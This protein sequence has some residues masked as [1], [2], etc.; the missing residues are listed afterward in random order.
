LRVSDRI[1][2]T[3]F[4]DGVETILPSTWTVDK[5]RIFEV[6]A[7]ITAGGGTP[8]YAGWLEGAT[9]VCQ[10]CRHFQS[11]A[12]NRVILISDGQVNV[13]E[14]NSDT[15]AIDVSELARRGVS[16]SV[17]G[18]GDEVNENL[19]S[20]IAMNLSNL[21]LPIPLLLSSLP[22]FLPAACIGSATP[23]QDQ[24]PSRS[25]RKVAFDINSAEGSIQIIGNRLI[26]SKQL[27]KGL[28]NEITK[29]ENKLDE[30]TRGSHSNF[31]RVVG[32]AYF[33]KGQDDWNLKF[34][35]GGL[36]LNTTPEIILPTQQI[37]AL[38][39]SFK[40]T[41]W[42]D[43]KVRLHPTTG[44]MRQLGPILHSPAS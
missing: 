37:F 6:L 19:L 29:A 39:E 36:V 17:V 32:L 13:R 22:L 31:S 40:Q 5:K 18:I 14:T 38:Q 7:H 26:L 42:T 35:F 2:I 23:I 20:A 16:T 43:I 3:L 24:S 30:L 8:L 1:S 4:A 15:I 25:E 44:I 33:H 12:I 11:Q 27:Q 10:V 28:K 41:K 21:K 9:Q 34:T